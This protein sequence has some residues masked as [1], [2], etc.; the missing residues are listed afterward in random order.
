MSDDVRCGGGLRMHRAG[1]LSG[2]KSRMLRMALSGL[3]LAAVLLSAGCARQESGVQ[4]EE[5]E[6]LIYYLNSAGT[7]LITQ[8]YEAEASEQEPLVEELMDQ[9]L[10]VPKDLDCQPALSDKVI[11]QGSRI[12]E[13]VLYLYFDMNYT[14]MRSDR[15]ILCRAALARTLTQIEGIGY[16]SICCGEQPLMDAQGNPVGL[17][18]ASDFIMNMSNVNAYEKTE[19][20]LYFADETGN[21]LVEEKREVVHSINTSLEQL[22]V[23]QLIAGP[24]QEGGY[25]VMPAGC[26][27]L[28]MSV[29][30]NVC[31]INFDAEFLNNSLPVNEY[32]PFYAIVNTLSEMTAVAKV[33]IMINGSQ[34]SLFRDVVPLNGTFERNQDYILTE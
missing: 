18:S 9:F 1:R 34:D 15:E 10:H 3:V 28:S 33:Q 22:I 29:T 31:Y 25:P 14:S 6:Y 30:D 20:T 16:V 24:E 13:Q 2:V 12:E 23:E 27:I 5:G 11:Y 17:V 4:P 26:K 19:L 7:K 32:I 21:Y 8:S